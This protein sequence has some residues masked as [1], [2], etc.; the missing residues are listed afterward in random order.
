MGG[1]KKEY[2]EDEIAIFEDACVYK[3]GEYWQ[4]RLWL[5]K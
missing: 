3:R 2:N 1:R 5:D 4:F